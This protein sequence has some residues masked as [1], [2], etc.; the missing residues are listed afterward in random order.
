M[1]DKSYELNTLIFFAEKLTCCTF[2]ERTAQ[3]NINQYQGGPKN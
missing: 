3:I 2:Y 1:L